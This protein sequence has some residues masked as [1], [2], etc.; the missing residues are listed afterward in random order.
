MQTAANTRRK[1]SPRKML[2]AVH[3]WAGFQLALLTFVVLFTG[4]LAVVAD[5]IDWLLDSDRRVVPTARLPDWDGMYDTAAALHPEYS[6]AS[7]GLGELSVMAATVRMTKPDGNPHLVF[8][9][10]ASGEL[11]GEGHW[12]SAHRILRDLHR[13]LFIMTLG[14]GLPVVTVAAV[15]LAVQLVTGLMTIRRWRQ[16]AV[17]V[18][19]GKGARVLIGDLHRAAGLWTVWFTLLVVI[20]SLWYFAEWTM[21][22]SGYRLEAPR[23]TSVPVS[24]E[25]TAEIGA[26][27]LLPVAHYVDAAQSAFPE[28]RP[29]TVRLP[30]RPGGTVTV[31]GRSTTWLLRDRASRVFLD[32][33]DASVLRVQRPAELMVWQYVTELADPWHFG[34]VGGLATKLLWF[35]S[36]LVLTAL[37]ATGVWLT[38]RRTQQGIGRWHWATLGIMGVA[39]VFGAGYISRYLA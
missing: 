26:A 1:R 38:W 21:V 16:A 32:P 4:T 25:S 29:T 23:V 33:R 5:E 11:R 3:S 18:R 13:Y 9:H 30:S 7:I 20:T 36:G 12:L 2:Y 28:L 24:E 34:D 15:V 37:S 6:V 27:S 39:T 31:Y 35:V 17:T 14:L 22:R 19:A 8:V 10:P